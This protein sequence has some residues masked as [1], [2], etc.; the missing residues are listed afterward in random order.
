METQDR[1]MA[2]FHNCRLTKEIEFCGRSER[3]K[4]RTC[5]QSD[6]AGPQAD[7]FQPASLPGNDEA[8]DAVQGCCD[9]WRAVLLEPRSLDNR[10]DAVGCWCQGWTGER[11]EGCRPGD[12]AVSRT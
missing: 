3:R 8:R 7:C 9:G 10:R 4:I 5:R 1:H 12:G 6:P 2:L 11:P